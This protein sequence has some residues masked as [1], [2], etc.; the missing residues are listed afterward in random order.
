M[1]TKNWLRFE[2]YAVWGLGRSGVAAANLLAR[3][4]K[5]VVA[6]DI[7]P[8]QELSDAIGKLD[9]GVAVIG[10]ENEIGDAEVIVTS[11]GLRP[12]LEIFD[13][14]RRRD[15]PVISEVDLAFDASSST[16]LAITGTDGKTTTTGLVGAMLDAAEYSHVVAG[17]IGV[18]L[19]DVVESVG[20][21]GVVVAEVSANQLWSCHH[22]AVDTAAITN[23]AEDH[24]D[25]FDDFEDYPRAKHRLVELQ[26]PDEHAVLP[27]GD[28]AIYD[29]VEDRCPDEITWF[30]RGTNQREDMEHLVYF[31]DDGVG[32]WRT[33]DREGR[34][35][36]DFS[37]VDL[38]GP[39]NQLNACCA[40]AMARTVG[41]CWA[42]IA[43]GLYSYER[44]P[45]RME[46]IGSVG[47]IRFIDDSKATNAHASL[48]GLEGI[49]GRLVVIA[50]GLDKG[51]DLDEW[52]ERVANRADCAV[53][54]G[55]IQQRMVE[56][57]ESCGGTVF[58]AQSLPEAVQRAHKQARPGSTVVLS[59]AC[60]SYDMFSSYKE[61]GRVFQQA[62]ADLSPRPS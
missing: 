35:I 20:D 13:E 27:A 54:I 9:G 23:I 30:G 38:I 5:S 12:G 25:Y 58:R 1:T 34:W 42:D 51:L 11:P 33:A 60:S 49:E 16:W 2:R 40:A 44:P 31:D 36:D 3:H 29:A 15:I 18:A 37:A 45:H 55:E 10:G 43:Q 26:G 14:A 52:A 24:R 22:L 50:G 59:P 39:H 4:Q 61:R 62:V 57:V 47:T 6:S 46:P 56:L 21:D 7:R 19:C 8:V 53:I 17:N 32:R 28:R 41:V 48:A